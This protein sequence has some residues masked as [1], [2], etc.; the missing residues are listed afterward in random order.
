MTAPSLLRQ[1]KEPL[2]SLCPSFRFVW[3]DPVKVPCIELN[4]PGELWLQPICQPRSRGPD[5]LPR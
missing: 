3:D 2:A 5:H 4:H 1:N